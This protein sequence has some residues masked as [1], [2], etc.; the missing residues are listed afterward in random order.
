MIRRLLL[1]LFVL[2]L[3]VM[4]PANAAT[5]IKATITQLTPALPTTDSEIQLTLTLA[6]PGA[7][8]VNNLRVRFL[9]STAPLVGRSQIR[10][11]VDGDIVPTYRVIERASASDIDLASGASTTITMRTSVQALGLDKDRPGVYPFGVVVDGGSTARAITF[12]PWLPRTANSKPLGVVPVLSLTAPPQMSIDGVFMNEQLAAAVLPGGR[13][14]AQLDAISGIV[15]AT[16]LVDPLTLEAIQKLAAG[17]RIKIGDEV[18]AST[19]AE[20]SAASQW[21]ADLRSYAESAQVFAMPPADLDVL[22]LLNFKHREVA[23]EVLSGAAAR[24]EAVLGTT[25]TPTAVQLYQGNLGDGVWSL[26]QELRLDAV[27][28]SDTSYQPS[29]QRYTP[30]TPLEVAGFGGSTLVVD[31][32][33]ASIFVST[34]P[35]QLQRQEL[36]AQLLMTYLEQPNRSRAITVVLPSVWNADTA[37][38]TATLFNA[39]WLQ[40]I[41]ILTASTYAADRRVVSASTMTNRQK[42]QDRMFRAALGHQ[43]TL[44]RL[45]VDEQFITTLDRTVSAMMSRWFTSNRVQDVYSERIVT[46]LSDY[47]ES[48]RVVTR[49]DIVF[50]GESGVV[51]VTIANGLP[52]PIDVVLGASGLPSVRVE[53]VARTALQINAGKRVSV[54]LPTRV[55]GSGLAYLQLWLET[56]DGTMIGEAVI[57]NIKSAAYARVASYLVAAAFITLLLLIG[58]NVVRRIRTSRQAT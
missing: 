1:A 38:G 40:P 6:N 24:V 21:L 5:G 11:I 15:G 12:L 2:V 42:Q 8:T 30:S 53:P 41:D 48:V 44:Q 39:A 22:A 26:L 3:P 7:E 29:Q 18:R 32:T 19:D 36:A 47:V 33:I 23:R 25:D 46:E 17:V 57:L 37:S 14:R 13:L 45:T 27:F 9:I 10:D 52:V 43:R 31:Q 54:E 51:P 34:R 58:V 28:V 49:G 50:G 20:M 4:V 55:T 35:E 16:L 56:D